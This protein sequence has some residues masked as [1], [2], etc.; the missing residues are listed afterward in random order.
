MILGIILIALGIIGSV[1]TVV[2][3]IKFMKKNSFILKGDY[4]AYSIE[5]E[6]KEKVSGNLVDKKKIIN[7]T[8]DT[9]Y[10]NNEC[11]D[12]TL[13]NDINGNDTELL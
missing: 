7:D 11:N 13:L 1:G 8:Y 10:L 5:E 6:H 2:F 4:V 12:T 3:S 9:V